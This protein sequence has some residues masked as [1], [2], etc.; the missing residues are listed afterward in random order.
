[1]VRRATY[2]LLFVMSAA[3]PGLSSF[4]A[5]VKRA[6]ELLSGRA[7]VGTRRVVRAMVL[8]VN[9]IAMGLERT[10]GEVWYDLL[11]LIY[12]FLAEST[13]ARVSSDVRTPVK[14]LRVWDWR[15]KVHK[16]HVAGHVEFIEISEALM[17]CFISSSLSFWILTPSTAPSP[18]CPKQRP[19]S[20]HANT[21][22][23]SPRLRRDRGRRRA[24]EKPREV[25]VE[26][27]RT[28]CSIRQSL[29]SIS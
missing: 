28:I 9:M 25:P 26:E 23:R 24:K 16:G 12:S 13:M 14:S 19:K 6:M 4:S 29:D 3:F 7:R 20:Y 17:R 22:R 8:M 18:T 21:R 1:M 11:V 10:R 27:E 5:A 15:H 2:D